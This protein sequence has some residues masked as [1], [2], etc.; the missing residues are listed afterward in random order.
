MML[1]MLMMAAALAMG[2][3]DDSDPI[4]KYPG[5]WDLYR[6]A[7]NCALMTS[8][9][10]GDFLRIAYYPKIDKVVLTFGNESFKDMTT[11]KKFRLHLMFARAGKLDDHWGVVDAVSSDLGQYGGAYNIFLP[12]VVLEDL[13]QDEAIGLTD[14]DKPINKLN[15]EQLATPIEGMK[16]CSR[17]LG[18]PGPDAP[19]T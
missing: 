17:A 6:N 14:D 16:E 5:Q 12:P 7:D 8:Y 11:G 3:G 15:I 2:G 9:K 18:I 1:N 13:A 10:G 4:K 19:K